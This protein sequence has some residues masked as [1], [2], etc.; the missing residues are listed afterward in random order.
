MITSK[1]KWVPATTEWRVLRM[2]MEQQLPAWRVAVNILNKQSRTAD[3]GWSCGLRFG[4]GANNYKLKKIAILR[5]VHN[6]LGL[7]LNLW[8]R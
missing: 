3:K 1:Y 4:R 5:N 6:C 8:T 2:R 7:G